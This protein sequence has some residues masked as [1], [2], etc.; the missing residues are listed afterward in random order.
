MTW[1]IV[2]LAV[3]ASVAAIPLLAQDGPPVADPP[4][5]AE[6]AP[7]LAFDVA[8]PLPGVPTMTL[9]AAVRRALE[10]NYALLSAGDDLRA[11]QARESAAHAQ[12]LPRVVPTAARDSV[13]Q[14]LGLDVSQRVPWTGATVTANAILRDL[15]D[16]LSPLPRSSG[17]GFSVT[18]PLLRGFGENAATFDLVNSERSR[19][20]QE[21]S[22]AL[23]RQRTA[24]QVASAYYAVIQQRQLH[25][26]SA[27]SLERTRALLR[28]SQARLEVGLVSKLDVF[29]AELQAAQAE[30]SLLT[31]QTAL[32]SA[33][34]QLRTLL[35]L[36][37][38]TPVE[39]PAVD[40]AQ[41]AD[42]T[43]PPLA[44]LVE[45][46]KSHR[47]DLAETR[48]QVSDARRAA[49]LAKQSLWPKLDVTVGMTELGTGTTFGDALGARDRRFEVAFS[50][51]YP[52]DAAGERANVEVARLAEQSRVRA[53]SQ[54]ELQLEAEVR[55]AVRE[56]E[57]LGK[58]VELQKKSVQVAE[59]QHRLATL[60]Y[61]RGLA[62]NF[63][64]V[65]AEG[66]LVL[67]RSALVNLLASARVAQL[68][69]RRVT[70]T[71]DVDA[72]FGS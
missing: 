60:R 40:L 55:Q 25:A 44:Q 1:G 50:S 66:N 22:L 32:E 64:V 26:V 8:G 21:R 47:L 30:S 69:L 27:Q 10:R 52:I 24:V 39:P 54:Q 53:V 61:Q 37:L 18:Q 43:V 72:E 41:D 58:S 15:R 49:Q 36:P 38:D 34:E 42:F 12:F 45:D 68:D 20:A 13:A 59:Q 67:A 11:A 63:D 23:S 14:S 17:L 35:S 2:V 16:P 46:A 48:D 56:I 31:T 7:A 3:V 62:S 4:A 9:A 33:R 71:L 6:S 19:Q 28:A 57:R 29:R 51:S 5:A 70:G 65:E